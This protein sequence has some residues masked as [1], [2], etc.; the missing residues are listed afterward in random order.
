MTRY[1]I[2]VTMS[3]SRPRCPMGKVKAEWSGA[4]QTFSLALREAWLQ[5]KAEGWRVD[6]SSEVLC[7]LCSGVLE[8]QAQGASPFPESERKR[9]S[10]ERHEQAWLLRLDGAT[11]RAIGEQLGVS[12]SRAHQMVGRHERW[13]QHGGRAWVW[14]YPPEVRKKWAGWAARQLAEDAERERKWAEQGA[15][16]LAEATARDRLM[17]AQRL[18]R[19]TERRV[20][21][22][23]EARQVREA[24][25]AA[26]RAE[27]ARAL[28]AKW[29]LEEQARVR[30]REEYLRQ[31]ELER[32]E[33]AV[34]ERDERERDAAKV[35][36][37]FR[38]W[39]AKPQHP[40][41]EGKLSVARTLGLK[42]GERGD[43]RVSCP[44]LL[45]T[46]EAY[47]WEA[48]RD[49][50]AAMREREAELEREAAMKKKR[51]AEL[52]LEKARALAGDAGEEPAF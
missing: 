47:A 34:K 41:H 44:Y 7:P 1:S 30:E 38:A 45:G 23:A 8:E 46:E 22:R 52:E 39:L 11:M 3:C 6:E 10:R 49:F 31:A 25:L 21:E 12:P 42:A 16:L 14:R 43:E 32:V 27:M 29:D 19:E 36:A 40:N 15:R 20:A 28:Q 18:E 35:I 51:E 37:D 24:A 50:M 5:A 26:K 9:K 13:L 48:G 17:A 2:A 33:R 4:A